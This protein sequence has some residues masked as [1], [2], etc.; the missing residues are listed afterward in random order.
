MENTADLCAA[1]IPPAY[2]DSLFPLQYYFELRDRTGQPSL[3]PGFWNRPTSE[4]YF[5]VRQ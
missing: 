2:T 5:V 3:Y 1:V 4:P